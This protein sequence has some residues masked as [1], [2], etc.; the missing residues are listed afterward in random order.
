VSFVQSV[1]IEKYPVKVTE[2]VEG[3]HQSRPSYFQMPLISRP[4]TTPDDAF[5]HLGSNLV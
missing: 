4:L 3:R 5:S 1:E 2:T